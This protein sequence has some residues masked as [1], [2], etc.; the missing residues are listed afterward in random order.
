MALDADI[1]Q[2]NS[3]LRGEISAVETYRQAR[4]RVTPLSVQGELALCQSSHELRVSKLRGRIGAL[5]A[6]AATSSGAWGA[7]ARL[8][9]GT[10]SALGDGALL[11]ALEQG[12]DHGRDDYRRGIDGMHE[13]DLVEFARG[14]LEEQDHTWRV[15]H[16][17]R[18]AHKGEHAPSP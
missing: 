9:A 17:L 13:R 8:T 16:T 18:R 2:L 12:E 6:V 14:L 7:I 5:G 4:E 1:A 10:A 15:V 3:F 11:L